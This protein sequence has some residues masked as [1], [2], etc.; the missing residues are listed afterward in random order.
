MFCKQQYEED[1]KSNRLG[2]NFCKPHIQQRT[3]IQTLKNFETQ[4]QKTHN[5]V[6]KMK[7]KQKTKNLQ[8]FH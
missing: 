5:P 6:R 8:T 2:E 7:K 3:G 1:E 4:Q